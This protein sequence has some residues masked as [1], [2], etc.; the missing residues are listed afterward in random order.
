M[1]KAFGL[2][3]IATSIKRLFVS[4]KGLN[5]QNTYGTIAFILGRKGQCVEARFNGD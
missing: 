3:A 1:L 2:R 4:L 5:T